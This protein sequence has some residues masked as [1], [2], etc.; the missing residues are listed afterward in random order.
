EGQSAVDDLYLGAPSEDALDRAIRGFH[1]DVTAQPF[2]ELLGDP[3]LQVGR[4]LAAVASARSSSAATAAVAE[5]ARLLLR[6]ET[7]FLF[8][9]T[10][11]GFVQLPQTDAAFPLSTDETAAGWW[12]LERSSAVVLRVE[13]A[14]TERTFGGD[15]SWL[16]LAACG[17]TALVALC[18]PGVLPVY[19]GELERL[20]MYGRAAAAILALRSE[21]PAAV[22][23][24]AFPAGA[25]PNGALALRAQEP[26][27]AA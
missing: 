20:V 15:D 21:V 7:A 24:Q 1:S 22:A 23:A 2:S 16:A 14:P 17:P 3:A 8:E 18:R 10:A 4:S 11:G 25:L 6:G 26:P 5:G 12:C 9:A 27:A 19:A 13:R